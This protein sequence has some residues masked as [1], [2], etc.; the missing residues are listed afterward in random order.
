MQ[1]TQNSKP[2]QP[3]HLLHPI[4]DF[5][6]LHHL[7][8]LG[9][10]FISSLTGSTFH[11]FFD[12][13]LSHNFFK[14]SGRLSFPSG[15]AVIGCFYDDRPKLSPVMEMKNSRFFVLVAGEMKVQKKQQDSP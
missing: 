10:T 4:N 15:F 1:P 11:D 5:L 7:C 2:L 8:S 14:E 6:L 13:L 9:S 12:H 3:D